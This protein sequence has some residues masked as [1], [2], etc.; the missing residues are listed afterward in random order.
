MGGQTRKRKVLHIFHFY[1]NSDTKLTCRFVLKLT[2]NREIRANETS[3]K[4]HKNSIRFV[5]NKYQMGRQLILDLKN[6]FGE[7]DS[8]IISKNYKS[9]F[10]IFTIKKKKSKKWSDLYSVKPATVEPNQRSGPKKR[11]NQSQ[12]E[13]EQRKQ[14]IKNL[15]KF[16][17]ANKPKEKNNRYVTAD[18]EGFDKYITMV[19]EEDRIMEEHNE[20]SESTNSRA[21]G[22][23]K[24]S[25]ERMQSNIDNILIKYEMDDTPR[26]DNRQDVKNNRQETMP[27]IKTENDYFFSNPNNKQTFYSSGNDPNQQKVLGKASNK[28]TY[29][30][31]RKRKM[32]DSNRKGAK[33]YQQK[34]RENKSNGNSYKNRYIQKSQ[35]QQKRKSKSSNLKKSN[36]YHNSQN[37]SLRKKT[38][39]YA[40]QFDQL[41]KESDT[42]DQKRGVSARYSSNQEPT[43]KSKFM[44]SWLNKAESREHY[45]E[46]N[47]GSQEHVSSNIARQGFKDSS[48]ADLMTIDEIIAQEM[49][50]SKLNTELKKA[51]DRRKFKSKTKK[52]KGGS[53]QLK[54]TVH[55]DIDYRKYRQEVKKGVS[56]RG[57]SQ[58]RHSLEKRERNKLKFGTYTAQEEDINQ[59]YDLYKNKEVTRKK[60]K[61]EM[62]HREKS[63][64]ELQK[65][66]LS[67][68]SMDR[69]EV[70]IDSQQE[71]QK[72]S[73][74]GNSSFEY[75]N[76]IDMDSRRISKN[77]SEAEE[78]GR[79]GILISSKSE[80]QKS[81]KKN[82][83]L[84]PF[85]QKTQSQVVFHSKKEK[86]SMG[87]SKSRPLKNQSGFYE[88]GSKKKGP[89][90]RTAI[91]SSTRRSINQTEKNV[92]QNLSNLPAHTIASY[93]GPNVS[94]VSKKLREKREEIL[95]TFAQLNLDMAWVHRQ[96]K[97][98]DLHSTEGVLK[99]FE[100]QNRLIV[101]IATKLRR[102]KNSRFK[103]EKQCEEMM[104]NFKKDFR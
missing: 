90:S 45:I 99:F 43:N 3:I 8:K 13:S 61:F 35:D 59:I 53:K 82:V 76:T 60:N 92:S 40:Q 49:K 1:F 55:S 69:I 15:K 19:P 16:N 25:F 101:K 2:S 51:T 9:N 89:R 87:R 23:F 88:K 56:Y 84:E 57:G 24:N 98:I 36:G 41:E 104:D 93:E 100:L 38:K 39:K 65:L 34:P 30:N 83:F 31:Q 33:L 70:L 50:E 47:G 22:Q 32:A 44:N 102:E 95:D 97:Y 28:S 4:I 81:R 94:M 58:P 11:K 48:N 18:E 78:I 79:K 85:K 54:G 52:K 29:D 17:N 91:K 67:K 12:S 75:G 68:K 27:N 96:C 42:Q 5:F 66:K 86:I 14:Y 73:F 63:H 77:N 64:H 20:G 103:V 26:A 21:S 62:K 6:L 80:V 37:K 10:A 46:S 74:V 71:L 72:Q 7:L